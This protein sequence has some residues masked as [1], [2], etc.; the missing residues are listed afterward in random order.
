[1][2]QVY[3]GYFFSILS[4]LGGAHFRIS[5][6][7]SIH[8]LMFGL[9]SMKYGRARLARIV[10]IRT[11]I[12]LTPLRH[13]SGSRMIL[14]NRVITMFLSVLSPDPSPGPGNWSQQSPLIGLHTL[15]PRLMSTRHWAE[16]DVPPRILRLSDRPTFSQSS[17]RARDRRH[18]ASTQINGSSANETDDAG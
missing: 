18:F 14:I 2:R 1:M 12:S 4:A 13:Y 7:H 17:T 8:D 3:D 15:Y 5:C 16:L 6:R 9:T 11:I 10:I